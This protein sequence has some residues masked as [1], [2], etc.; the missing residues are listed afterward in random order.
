MGW[1]SH[2]TTAPVSRTSPRTPST[3]CVRN[4]RPRVVGAAPAGGV[5]VADE[6]IVGLLRLLEIARLPG[7]VERGRL[8]PVD[9]EV[10]EPALARIRLNPLALLTRRGLRADVAIDRRR[11]AAVLQLEQPAQPGLILRGLTLAPRR[12]LV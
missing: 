12:A 5:M 4:D 7:A 6:L 10:D 11:V 9:A 1:A 2:S 3:S 8:R